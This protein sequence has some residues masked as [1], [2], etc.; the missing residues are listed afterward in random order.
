M[1]LFKIEWPIVKKSHRETAKTINNLLPGD[2]AVITEMHA[3]SS[4]KQRLMDLG[5]IEGAEIEM[6]RAAPLGDPVEIKVHNT[7]VAIRRREAATLFIEEEKKDHHGPKRHRHRFGRKS[8][9]REE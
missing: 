8:Q 7:L 1:V 2:R 4:I 6:V 9:L 3:A 5:I